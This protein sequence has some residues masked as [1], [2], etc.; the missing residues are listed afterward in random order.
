M[1]TT[2]GVFVVNGA[3][4]QSAIKGV[5]ANVSASFPIAK[6]LIGDCGNGHKGRPE[7]ELAPLAQ[8]TRLKNTLEQL[9]PVAIMRASMSR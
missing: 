5:A 7:T 2:N 6:T 1:Y 8:P 3:A 4:A 9:P